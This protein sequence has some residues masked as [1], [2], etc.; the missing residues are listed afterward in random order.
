M[1]AKIYFILAVVFTAIFDTILWKSF[2]YQYTLSYQSLQLSLVNPIFA[3]V[4]CLL[5][6]I[7]IGHVWWPQ[8]REDIKTNV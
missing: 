5:I 4:P 7:V 3:A 1:V 2:G 6:G 8:Y